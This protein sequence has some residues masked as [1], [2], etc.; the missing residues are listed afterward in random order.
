MAKKSARRTRASWASIARMP[1]RSFSLFLHMTFSFMTGIASQPA[2]RQ[3]RT[4]GLPF[5]S[6]PGRPSKRRVMR[7]T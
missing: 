4:N 7:S 5:L 3:L 1:K 2:A 6:G